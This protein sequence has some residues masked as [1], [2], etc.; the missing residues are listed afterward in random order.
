[1][2][3]FYSGSLTWRDPAYRE[4]YSNRGDDLYRQNLVTVVAHLPDQGRPRVL[5]T[6]FDMAV[7]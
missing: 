5:G 4:A 7:R 2:I 1:M 3:V 6:R